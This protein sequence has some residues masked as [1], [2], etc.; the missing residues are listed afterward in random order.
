MNCL[1]ATL[2]VLVGNA[3]SLPHQSLLVDNDHEQK[4][5]YERHN[6]QTI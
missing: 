5:N 6:N 1:V 3:F 4:I 2:N